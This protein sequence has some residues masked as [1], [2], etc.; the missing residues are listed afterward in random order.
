MRPS[1]IAIV[2]R[3]D[4]FV[5]ESLICL[6]HYIVRPLNSPVGV[7]LSLETGWWVFFNDTKCW[8]LTLFHLP[9]LTVRRVLLLQHHRGSEQ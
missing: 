6:H 7:Q 4:D 2:K 8:L 9:L 3:N 5:V 1:L